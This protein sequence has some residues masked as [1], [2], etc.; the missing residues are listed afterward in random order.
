MLK[1]TVLLSIFGLVTAY[2]NGLGSTPQMGWNT[3]NKYGCDINETIILSTAQKMKDL[4][5]QEFGYEY[6][7]MDDC[8]ALHER[9]N[10][11]QKLVADPVKF[12][13]GIKYLSDQIHSLGFKFGMYSS[14]GKYTCGGYPGSLNYEE[15][16]AD[17]FAN[18]WEV[19]YLKYDNCFNEGN[20]GTPQISY[21][22]YNKMSQALNQT[23]RPIFYSLCQW[24][25]DSVWNWGSTLSNS[26]RISGDIYDNFDRYD[27]RCPCESYECVGLQ[28][29]MCS[30]VNI[31]EKAIPLGQKAGPT[32]GWNDMDMLEVGNGGMSFE[33]YKSHF[34][35][36]SILKSPLIL[37]NDV[38]NMSKDDF[39]IVTNKDV[40]AVN[41]DL[42]APGY[43][44]NKSNGASV[45]TNLLSDNS[46]V[47][48]VF[49]SGN[50]E[51]E[52]LVD[53]ED[54]FINNPEYL[55]AT[56]E[57][58]ELWTNETS[59]VNGSFHVDVDAHAVKIWKW[60]KQ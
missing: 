44:V 26:W 32:N 56:F 52:V 33:E 60:T 37:G 22:R 45:F 54:V 19:D 15:I 35:L 18:D 28:G 42:S 20:S 11:T 48:T 40:I 50:Q 39:G 4:G 36:W 55:N 59:I 12:P 53:Y 2:D 47:I 23:G 9:D 38:T 16:D 57:A 49:N 30:M 46:F 8:Y 14:A 41:Q 6:I 7:I 29:Y 3:W 31:L 13:N 10:V 51:Q 25:E 5:L 27:D 17:T 24:G 21:D 58:R 43:R 34:T 1:S